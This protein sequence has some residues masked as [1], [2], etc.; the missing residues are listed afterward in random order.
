MTESP[1]FELE[2]HLGG[3]V[4]VPFKLWEDRLREH[5]DPSIASIAVQGGREAARAAGVAI[6]ESAVTKNLDQ[7]LTVEDGGSLWIIPAR[8]V[9]AVKFTD[10]TIGS[11][12]SRGDGAAFGFSGDRLGGI[13]KTAR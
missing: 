9:L 10:P 4:V 11:R 1:P 8:S 5:R 13:E 7:P 6:A 2:L 3:G 12:G